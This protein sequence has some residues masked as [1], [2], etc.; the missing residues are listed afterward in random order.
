MGNGYCFKNETPLKR[1]E[2][3]FFYSL[4]PV[5]KAAIKSTPGLSQKIHHSLAKMNIQ[6]KYRRRF[7]R[8][9]IDEEVNLEST[10]DAYNHCRVKNMSVG[11]MFVAGFFPQKNAENC[12]IK[13]Y[14]HPNSNKPCFR[15]AV[16]V[17]WNNE[18]G[19]GLKFTAMNPESYMFL[20][21]TLINNAEQPAVIIYDLA[22]PCPFEIAHV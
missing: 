21:T 13:I 17:V 16:S 15:A 3:G 19:S 22:K 20:R 18:E 2:P 14:A 12:K 11:G 10:G 4:S 8:V 1:K 6:S 9:N 5:D 7:H